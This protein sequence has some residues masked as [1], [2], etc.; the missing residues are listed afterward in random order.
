MIT[1]TA[2]CWRWT[3][4]WHLLPPLACLI[5]IYSRQKG[6]LGLPVWSMVACGTSGALYFVTSCLVVP[7][8]L[9]RGFGVTPQEQRACLLRTRTSIQ[10]YSRTLYA[11]YITRKSL[12]L[13]PGTG[14]AY[15]GVE[16]SLKTPYPRLL[17]FAESAELS[18]CRLPQ[19][20]LFKTR[21]TW[22]L[23]GFEMHR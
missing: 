15:K 23:E 4:C 7:R 6:L 9:W 11:W 2:E 8:H 21:Y 5:Y 17:P 19:L 13:V 14:R 10:Q 16:Y 12:Y 1:S 3:E 22:Q 18:L 20:R